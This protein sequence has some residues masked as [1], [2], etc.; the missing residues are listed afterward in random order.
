ML[1]AKTISTTLQRCNAKTIS[2][3][4]STLTC[5]SHSDLD[6]SFMYIDLIASGHI[7]P[8]E[9]TFI[10]YWLLHLDCNSDHL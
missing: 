1:L 8:L 7:R 9:L 2:K 5:N 10:A 6:D 4:I 3:K